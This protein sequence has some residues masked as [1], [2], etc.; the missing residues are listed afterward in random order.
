MYST[1]LIKFKTLFRTS[2]NC[3]ILFLVL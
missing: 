2:G 1:D 3:D